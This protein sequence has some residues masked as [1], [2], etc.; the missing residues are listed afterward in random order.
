VSGSRLSAQTWVSSEGPPL[1]DDTFFDREL[2]SV[3]RFHP[4]DD[5]SLRCFPDSDTP[6]AGAGIYA[7]AACTEPAFL[8]SDQAAPRYLGVY[9]SKGCSS[10]LTLYEPGPAVLAFV[11][12][13][14]CVPSKIDA[15]G[16][17]RRIPSDRF[18]RAAEVRAP[19]SGALGLLQVSAEDGTAYVTGLYD[20]SSGQA[21]EDV[22][23]TSGLRCVAR[24]AAT[25]ALWASNQNVDEDF[26]KSH[27][28][29]SWQCEPPAFGLSAAPDGGWL[30]KELTAAQDA[31]TQESTVQACLDSAES[32]AN[33]KPL[34]VM[35]NEVDPVGF[36]ELLREPRAGLRISDDAALL[37][38]SGT[39][40]LRGRMLRPFE[41]VTSYDEELGVA[42]R[43][44]FAA[45]GT[46]RCM[47][48]EFVNGTRFYSDPSCTTPVF[49][50]EPWDPIR[51]WTGRAR[52]GIFGDGNGSSLS[53]IAR[54]GDR[55]TGVVYSRSFDSCAE[56]ATELEL[57]EGVEVLPESFVKYELVR[58]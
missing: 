15:V 8:P 12:A 28:L 39:A 2:D 49:P 37:D 33:G 18:V 43:F 45:D 36:P 21:C 31:G 25:S 11:K 29:V 1:F 57:L 3:C 54:L 34:Y 47:P 24:P 26:C 14:A 50:A 22:A 7:D 38:P 5:G 53:R 51:S 13:D 32:F 6:P 19:R 16:L 41:V 10:E 9:R 42:C 58:E 52:F 17:G 35:G 4:S 48:S 44:K 30:I 27:V 40:A 23:T 55:Y 56:D 20:Q 46:L